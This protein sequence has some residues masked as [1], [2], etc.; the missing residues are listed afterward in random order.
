MEKENCNI[1]QKKKFSSEDNSELN[2]T[3]KNIIKKNKTFTED[4][5]YNNKKKKIFLTNLKFGKNLLIWLLRKSKYIDEQKINSVKK[6]KKNINE[7]KENTI[8]NKQKNRLSE[9]YKITP[10][11]N[12]LRFLTDESMNELL[13]TEQDTSKY[14]SPTN[15]NIFSN[16]ELKEK[17]NI[18]RTNQRLH[19]APSKNNNKQY[20]KYNITFSS[21]NSNNKDNKKRENKKIINIKLSCDNPKEKLFVKNYKSKNFHNKVKIND[22]NLLSSANKNK[23]NLNCQIYTQ[24]NEEL[25]KKKNAKYKKIFLKKRNVTEI[26][27]KKSFTQQNL[28]EEKDKFTIKESYNKNG[29]NQIEYKPNKIFNKSSKVDRLLFKLEN[30]YECFEENVSSNRPED[31]FISFKNQI[32]KQ[33]NKTIKMFYEY[34]KQLRVNES[35]M[36]K[37]IYKIFSDRNKK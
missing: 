36:T 33:K 12:K 34:K 7:A 28:L 3:Q 11:I 2:S 37:Y 27:K 31:K 10:Q 19:I 8:K 32:V 25:K 4:N 26:Q 13:K 18:F 30:P 35:H 15:I 16:N 23:K 21:L 6:I 9:K 22:R 29:K 1:N 20:L 14:Y 17:I 24:L 5:K